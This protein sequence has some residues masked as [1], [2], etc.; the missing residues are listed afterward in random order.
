LTVHV[1]DISSENSLTCQSADEVLEKES[2]NICFF[3]REAATILNW[4][5][6][7]LAGTLAKHIHSFSNSLL[8]SIIPSRWI[9]S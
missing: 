3:R 8:R 4:K 7:A 9:S 6:F 1:L 5:L 2:S